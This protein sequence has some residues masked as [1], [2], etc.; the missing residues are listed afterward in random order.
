MGT[1]SVRV[2]IVYPSDPMG[3]VLGGIET[4]IRGI[5]AWAPDDITFSMIGGTTDPQRR[6]MARWTDCAI[7]ERTLRLFPLFSRGDAARQLRIPA[8]IRLL[9]GLAFRRPRDAFDL[10]QFHRI[11]PSLLFRHGAIPRVTFIHQNMDNLKAHNADIRWRHAPAFYFRLEDYL[12]PKFDAVYGVHGGAVASYQAR[13]PE[14]KARISFVPTW[15]DPT[16]FFPLSETERAHARSQ[17]LPAAG[18]DPAE[19]I[20]VWVGRIDRQKNPALLIDAFAAVA[21]QYADVRL[22]MIGDGNLRPEIEAQ[23]AAA[24][25]HDKVR[26]LGALVAGEVAEWMKIGDLLALSS[27]YEGM[28]RC[29]VEALGSGMPVATTDVG[30]VRQVV[31]P[32]INGEISSS[33]SVE[34]FSGAITT[35]LQQ[36]DKYRGRPCTRATEAFTPARVL[37]PVYE[38]YRRLA[39]Q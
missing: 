13:F 20:I 8:T 22:V 38:D 3:A 36:L 28:P 21:G 7:G 14:R 2:C 34:D 31:Q 23:I 4:C 30:E 19:R 6:P 17:K 35:C 25:L 15:M 12:M 16:I 33:S 5:V 11:E 9:A 39:R 18:L 1:D 24:G 10:L 27:A 32:G 29:V 37:Q 26:L